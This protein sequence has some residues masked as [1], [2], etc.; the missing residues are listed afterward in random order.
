MSIFTKINRIITLR[1]GIRSRLN[2]LGVVTT[3]AKFETCKTALDNISDNT[4][5][6]TPSNPVKGTFYSGTSQKV[7]GKVG[8]GYCSSGTLVEVPVTN[9]IAPFIK[10]G[11]NIGG[12]VGSYTEGIS[13]S[14]VF[15][16]Y[17]IEGSG[18]YSDQNITLRSYPLVITRGTN[19]ILESSGSSN[20]RIVGVGENIYAYIF[21]VTKRGTGTS[22]GYQ[23]AYSFLDISNRISNNVLNLDNLSVT[24]KTGSSATST[25]RYSG[26]IIISSTYISISGALY[27]WDDSTTTSYISVVSN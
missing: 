20:L 24:V 13:F 3:S 5:K 7:Y 15:G 21:Y 16:Q 22:T 19:F 25:V 2:I 10:K 26:S 8:E 14:K 11:I 18:Y 1:N 23:D 6:T 27:T 9:L 12:V 4:K 17:R